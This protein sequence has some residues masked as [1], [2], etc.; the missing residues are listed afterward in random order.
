MYWYLKA[1]ALQHLDAFMS[2][3][4]ARFYGLP[5]NQGTPMRLVKK[6]WTVPASYALGAETVVPLRAGEVMQWSVEK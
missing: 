5:P 2:K 4:G 1:G 3:N 6:E